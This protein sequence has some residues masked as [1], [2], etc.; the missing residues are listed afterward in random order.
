MPDLNRLVDAG[1]TSHSD[2]SF[3]NMVAPDLE[4]GDLVIL[5]E[6]TPEA[7]RLGLDRSPGVRKL[8]WKIEIPE[9]GPEG[10]LEIME[11]VA[12]ELIAEWA[13]REVTLVIPSGAVRQARDLADDYLVGMARPGRGVRL[14]REAVEDAAN[15]RAEAEEGRG[16]RRVRVG[17]SEVVATLSRLTGVP[18]RLI[19]DEV[20]LDLD[21]VRRFFSGRVL[22]QEPAVSAVVDLIGLIKTGLTDPTRPLGILFFVGPTGVGKTEMAKA[23]A[24]Y[25]F[26]GVEHL[27]RVDLGEYKE[28]Q[29]HRRLVGDPMAV[30]PSARVGLLTAPVRERPFSVV[31][32]DEVEKAHR[33]VFDLLLPLLAE[34]RLVDERGEVTDFRRTIVVMTSNLGCDPREGLHLGF[35]SEESGASSKVLRAMEEA[36]RPEFVNRIGKVVLFQ[37]FSMEVRRRL[38]RREV[39]RVLRRRGLVRRDDVEVECDEAIIG[40]FLEQG[41]SE[42]LGARPLK[43]R[44]EELLL[45]PVARALLKLGPRSAPAVIRLEVSEGRLVSQVIV[46]E[47]DGL[48]EEAALEAARSSAR[49]RD[50]R[51]GRLLDLDDLEARIEELDQRL[52]EYEVVVDAESLKARRSELMKAFTDPKTYAQGQ[53]VSEIQSEIYAIGESLDTHER[54]NHQ[55]QRLWEL[56]ERVLAHPRDQRLLQELL[57]RSEDMARRIEFAGYEA[58]CT[59]SEERGDAYVV[60]TR[61]GEADAPE[62]PISLLTKMYQSYAQGKGFQARPVLESV[63]RAGWLRELTLRVEGNCAYGLL[64]GESGLH[65]WVYREAG[66]RAKQVAFVRVRVIPPADEDL[67]SDEVSRESR[68]AEEGEGVFLKPRHHLVLAHQAGWVALDGHSDRRRAEAEA[69]AQELL[70]ARVAAARREPSDPGIV[71]RYVRSSQSTVRDLRTQVKD[72]LDRV[73]DGQLDAFVLPTS[74]GASRAEESGGA[75]LASESRGA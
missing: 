48:D 14:L 29:S 2:A 51:R 72:H 36:F 16:P 66:K 70:A 9:P 59:S 1:T 31:L 60:L 61:V 19:D 63:T 50:P 53:Q 27:V 34:G 26:G 28:P 11:A 74:F 17:P 39:Q 12:E 23:L 8:F 10:A 13:E 42:R 71:R 69:E 62:D 35:G 56:Y 58:S 43:R 41:F 32:L 45:T 25:L 40:F 15:P 37:S 6:S 67:Q 3:A 75:E 64:R 38:I 49:V 44:V 52:R 21:E 33:N 5:G 7:L 46:E 55:H 20:E 30:E 57:G 24:E 4:R 73:L 47:D 22:G 54:L 65:Q 68:V 18:Q